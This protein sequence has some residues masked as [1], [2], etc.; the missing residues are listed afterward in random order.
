MMYT[1][2]HIRGQGSYEVAIAAPYHQQKST[3][4]HKYCTSSFGVLILNQLFR[5]C[6]VAV[7]QLAAT[8]PTDPFAL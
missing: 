8:A 3:D 2:P 4:L 1:D 7:V 6:A 5:Y